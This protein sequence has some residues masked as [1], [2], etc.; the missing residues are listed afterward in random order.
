MSKSQ[1]NT[2]R[3]QLPSSID[4]EKLVLGSLLM[5]NNLF[6]VVDAILQTQDFILSVHREIY[7][8]I[9]ELQEA[10]KPTDIFS[11]EDHLS[12]R[13]S[14]E[15]IGGRPYLAQLEHQ[16]PSPAN[17][18]HYAKI[19]K[20]K[21]QRR[22]IIQLAHQ[23]MA[24]AHNPEVPLE[25][26]INEFERSIWQLSQR[27]DAQSE[28]PVSLD[29]TLSVVVDYL[30]K[31]SETDGDIMGLPTGYI[32]LDKRLSG[33]YPADYV[34]FA[35][36]PSMGK[37]ACAMGIA[38]HVAIHQNKTVLI[39]S[40]EMVH[41][42]LGLRIIAS[43]GRIPMQNIRTGQLEDVQWNSVTRSVSQ[44]TRKPMYIDDSPTL[45][46]MQMRSRARRL[47]RRHGLDLIIIDYLQ[48][49][50]IPGHREGKVN[51]VTDISRA[52]KA[53]AK[54]L[55]I[56]ILALSQLNRSVEQRT[57]KRPLMA[58]LRESGAIEQDADVITFLYRDEYYNPDTVD[59]GIAE[60]ITVK[61]RNGPV[62]VD[63][64]VFQGEIARFDNNEYR[65]FEQE[66]NHP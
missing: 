12:R 25:D 59:T 38:N 24:N 64:L 45:T 48:L 9:S 65:S 49:M 7:T 33:L 53:L 66:K 39:F 13:K 16:V 19:V 11:V 46:P 42:M 27:G 17:V 35:G 30:E 61:Q 14:L 3:Q 29:E 47:A 57:C 54:E 23:M 62:G 56:P 10:D 60:L 18:D 37:T 26:I 21:S 43:E 40:M 52:I 44:C 2:E 41:L 34:V 36:R 58:D 22:Q 50:H 32:D 51:M 55:N 6:E 31:A 20:E 15:Q 1:D 63:R 28:G 4:S 5:R 8:A